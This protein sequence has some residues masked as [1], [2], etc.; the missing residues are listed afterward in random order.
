MAK[1]PNKLGRI[2]GE[3][4]KPFPWKNL[5][6]IVAGLVLF[7]TGIAGTLGYQSFIDSVK[8]QGV[9]DYQS[10]RCDRYENEDKSAIWLECD[11]VRVENN[12]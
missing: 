2:E 1:K 6:I 3:P 9:A 12:K 5:G 10:N 11:A 4:K 8:A 7:A